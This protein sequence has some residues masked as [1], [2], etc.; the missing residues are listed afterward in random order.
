MN[1]ERQGLVLGPVLAA[2]LR[3]IAGCDKGV[4]K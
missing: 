4:L 1:N 3:S 2:K